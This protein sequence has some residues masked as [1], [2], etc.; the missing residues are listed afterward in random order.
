M[1]DARL[2][3]EPTDYLPLRDYQ[4]QAIRTI[5]CHIAAGQRELLVAMATGTGKTITCIGLAYRLI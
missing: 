3:A 1:A 5:E 2:S 4:A